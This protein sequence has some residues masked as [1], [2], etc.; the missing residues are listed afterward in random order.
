MFTAF[1]D[2]KKNFEY[3][4]MLS[5]D[6]KNYYEL[7]REDTECKLIFDIEWYGYRADK[8]NDKF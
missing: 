1:K 7:I 2:A 3:D 6:D 4:N 8:Q 5:D